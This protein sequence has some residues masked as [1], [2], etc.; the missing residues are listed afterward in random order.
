[1]IGAGT[2]I[3][4]VDDM[5]T[6][7]LSM[8]HVRAR[9]I[10]P[11]GTV[12]LVWCPLWARQVAFCARHVFVNVLCRLGCGLCLVLGTNSVACLIAHCAACPSDCHVV[13][14][15]F[16]ACDHVCVYMHAHSLPAQAYVIA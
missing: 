10:G 12:R 13:R 3:T 6:R 15:G 5:D 4:H 8:R 16:L 2:V 7:G 1:M 14:G 11:I 9:I